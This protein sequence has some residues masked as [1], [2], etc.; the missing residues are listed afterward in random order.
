MYVCVNNSCPMSGNELQDDTSSALEYVCP[1]CKE[2]LL[3]KAS[4]KK[5]MLD[6]SYNQ[7]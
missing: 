1:V 4:I 7:I 2:K 3:E 5:S 6:F